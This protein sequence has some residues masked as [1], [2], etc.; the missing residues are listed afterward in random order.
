[1]S[2]VYSHHTAS[3]RVGEIIDEAEKRSVK[4]I[5]LAKE[6]AL[7]ELVESYLDKQNPDIV[8]LN[9]HGNDA[10]ITGHNEEVL[11]EAGKNSDLLKDKIV[12]M[13][14]CDS[15]KV[16]GPQVIKEGAR[17]FIGYTELFRFW[18]DNASVKNPLQDEYARPFFETSNQVAISLVRGKTAKESH[19]DSLR[20][21]EKIISELLTSDASNS[22]VVSDLI[23][24]MHNQV[25][26]EK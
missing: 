13:R 14:S 1:M 19:Q 7:R 21:Y 18:T 2:N 23:W 26:L 16:L 24:N 6:K 22:F 11:I 12:Y 3:I 5:D 25:C 4:V 15:G 9:G 17:S 10:C 20:I 8:V